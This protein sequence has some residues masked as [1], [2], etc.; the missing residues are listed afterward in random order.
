LELWG[1]LSK[2]IVKMPKFF[3]LD[4]GLCSRLQGHTSEEA[5]WNSPQSGSLFETMVFSELV[6]TRDNFLLDWEIFTWRTKEKHEIDFVLKSGQKVVLIESK[7]AIQNIKPLSLDSEATKVFTPQTP[8]IVCYAGHKM[9][10]LDQETLAVPVSNLG[11][12]LME[13]F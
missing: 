10:R 5:M 11:R 13:L 8:K 9:E 12:Y 1:L 3:M 4:S 2:R 7:M 6:K